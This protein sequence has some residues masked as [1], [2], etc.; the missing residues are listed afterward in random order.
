MKVSVQTMT[1][2]ENAFNQIL[3]EIHFAGET[4]DPEIYTMRE[5]LRRILGNKTTAL[6]GQHNSNLLKD[7]IVDSLAATEA[8]RNHSVQVVDSA[9]TVNTLDVNIKET[10]SDNLEDLINTMAKI[11]WSQ[12][13][14]PTREVPYKRV[15]GNTMFGTVL[16]KCHEPNGLEQGTQYDVKKTPWLSLPTSSYGHL[17]HAKQWVEEENKRRVAYYIKA[18]EI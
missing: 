18:G 11:H 12:E 6:P 17:G 2:L 3:N 5:K 9:K 1:R 10:A 15:I 4:A 13:C 8:L 16:I 14:Q 7:G